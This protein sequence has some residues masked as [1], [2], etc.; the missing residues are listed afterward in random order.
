MKVCR[1]CNQE[2]ELSEFGKH[3]QT[4]D[5]LRHECKVC[6][7]SE[8]KRYYKENKQD[9]LAKTSEYYK[10]NKDAHKEIMSKWW[11][12]N[13]QLDKEYRKRYREEKHEHMKALDR[14]KARK[15]RAQKRTIMENFTKQQEQTI[16]NIFCNVCFN[17]GSS[18]SLEIDHHYPLN[19]GFAL[20]LSNAVL[21]CKSCNCS[22]HDA[23]PEDFYSE[24]QL[25][26]LEY[27]LEM[28]H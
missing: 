2:K 11:K 10:E 13:R 20:E 17:C 28:L 27:I 7:K 9:V 15:R 19:K 1:I 8:S 21:L 16:R 5:R 24:H 4:K 22:K 6:R 18:K 14:V 26:Q 12:E 25:Y 23:M 3:S